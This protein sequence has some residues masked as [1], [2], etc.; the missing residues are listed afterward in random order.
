ME[1]QMKYFKFALVV[2]FLVATIILPAYALR[3]TPEQLL[4]S[5]TKS[6]IP[7][8]KVPVN[9]LAENALNMLTAKGT[10]PSVDWNRF[11]GYAR[12][13]AEINIGS[14][15]DNF[16]KNYSGL[17]GIKA[18]LSG[19]NSNR[20]ITINGVEVSTYDQTFKGLP[21]FNGQVKV[22]SSHGAVRMVIAEVLPG[23][24][25][26]INP[27]IS[28]EQA[29]AAAAVNL[30]SRSLTAKPQGVLGIYPDRGQAKL[31]YK[32]TLSS[33]DPLGYYVFYI[34]AKNGNVIYK[35]NEMPFVTGS[36]TVYLNN[37]VV[38]G[39]STQSFP[40]LDG[41]GNLKGTYAKALNE[42]VAVAYNASNVFSYTT[43]DTH[44]DENMAYFHV[45]RIHNYYKATLGYAGMDAVMTATVHV[46]TNYANA[47][48]DPATGQI[49]FGDGDN[50]TIFDTAKE[51]CVIYHEYTHAVTDK[52]VGLVYSGQSGAMSEGYSDYFSCSFTNDATIGEYVM[53][54]YRRVLTNH[55]TMSDWYG[56][57]HADG[58][59]WGHVLWECRS[60]ASIG[61][62]V[63]DKTTFT[64]INSL[65]SG[66]TFVDGLNGILNADQSLYSGI[67]KTVIQ[68][69]FAN[70]G[71]GSAP[72]TQNDAGSGADAGDTFAAALSLSPGTYT[73]LL[74]TTD[75]NDYFKFNVTSGQV[76]KVK[77][78]PPS[79]ADFD[80]YLYNPSQTQV[81]SS[82]AGTGAVDSVVYTA[83][84]TG[85]F[86]AKAYEYSGSGNYTLLISVGG[87]TTPTPAL[88]LSSTSWAPA[89]AGGTSSAI[90]VTNS[91]SSTVIAY[92]IA[93]N[94][95]WLTVSAASGNTPG[96][97]TMTASANTGAARTATVTVTATT[98][99]VTGSP[100]TISVSQTAGSTSGDTYEPND[101]FTG[102][103]GPQTSGLAYNSYI[104]S[105]TDVDY[106]KIS[107]IAAGIV[108]INL[109]NLPGDYDLYL[110][111]SAQ[112]QVA[113]SELGGTSAETI[114]YSATATGT[115][116]IKVVG[117]SGAYSTTVA[118]ALKATLP[119]G[120]AGT[121]TDVANTVQS[122]HPYTNSYTYTWTITGP[123]TATQ[124][125]V[126]FDSIKT[127]TGY[128]T[129]FVLN[130]AG[131]VI[132]KWTGTYRAVWSN[133]V[134]GNVVK[135]KIKSDA[136]VTGY[137]FLS[138][139]YSYYKTTA[140]LVQ[141]LTES[142]PD[143]PENKELLC[144]NYP[145]PVR[146][147]TLISYN[148]PSSRNVDLRIYNING[149]L[150]KTLVSGTQPAGYHKI[151][152]DGRDGSGRSVATGAYIYRLISGDLNAMKRLT[153]IR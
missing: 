146:G 42:D 137:G 144:Q 15:P 115:Y 46:G 80:L 79:T 95:T 121:W 88:S 114:S 44:F 101:A 18:D 100:K 151:N 76:I 36:G 21:V 1:P 26:D 75:R 83:T 149:Q 39:T 35:H 89:A 64:G 27:A 54:S 33:G 111:N 66:A 29:A 25:M 31:A 125:K 47:Y 106:Y 32:V 143:T 133:A 57:V 65:T 135:I 19:L 67:H 126:Y 108:T 87:G 43:T 24:E 92:T 127:E 2:V 148:L 124:M 86:Y 56:E 109:S 69:I 52:I 70:H 16:L 55:K 96:S 53:P 63:M 110:Y 99:G 153:V 13:I 147:G 140:V 123:T 58:E 136:S 128:D 20:S 51:E 90:N 91:G 34:D 139:K 145:N 112:T 14:T 103:Y 73:C 85:T 142:T 12:A 117:Y 71:I 11:T 141:S 22:T 8:T 37:P 10:V 59:I 30:N 74:N 68:N 102:A 97:F 105:S 82:T 119:T 41:S 49:Y 104:Y 45:D 118:Y 72:V 116:Y 17:L 131:T 120:S 5:K 6:D 152:W 107:V 38:G 122:A 84:T 77:I 9:P 40:N 7:E 28:A 23:I 134:A 62:T 61:A 48:Y 81:G 113:K 4:E 50:S 78:T 93:S 60:D 129:V 150:V 3:P 98:S 132:Q 94:Q 130:S 138:T